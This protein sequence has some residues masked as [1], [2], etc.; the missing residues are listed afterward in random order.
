MSREQNDS[1]IDKNWQK[2]TRISVSSQDN[3]SSSYDH[4]V[5]PSERRKILVIPYDESRSLLSA[6]YNKIL[7]R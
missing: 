7:P 6:E 1:G 4:M 3:V 5:I 2:W